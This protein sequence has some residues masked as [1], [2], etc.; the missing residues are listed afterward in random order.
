MCDQIEAARAEVE[1]VYRADSGFDFIPPY[2]DWPRD[3]GV[4]THRCVG[5]RLVAYV[6]TENGFLT[7]SVVISVTDTSN[8]NHEEAVK[9][10]DFVT[11]DIKIDVDDP[12]ER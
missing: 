8:I 3:L 11:P 5:S 4:S 9:L 6:D 10:A 2:C 7:N 12:T 1:R